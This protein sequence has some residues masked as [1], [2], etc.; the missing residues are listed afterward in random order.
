[1]LILLVGMAA[2]GFF[3]FRAFQ[4]DQGK[5]ATEPDTTAA[6][7]DD[8]D[9]PAA[10]TPVGE[11][12]EAVAALDELNSGATA[13]AG[14]LLGAVDDARDVMGQTD[15]GATTAD[16][17]ADDAT[18]AAPAGAGLTIADVL[19]DVVVAQGERLPD[20]SGRETYV[21]SAPTFSQTDA[22]AFGR[23]V[24]VLSSQPQIDPTSDVFAD[25]PELEPGAILISVDRDGDT[26]RRV[27]VVAADSG[28]YVDASQ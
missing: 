22:A 15:N 18:P 8:T 1:M 5:D 2:A 23:F 26:L 25:Y 10:L 11:Q 12:A 4:D 14:G 28:I 7:D 27:I 24:E 21:I 16:G 17:T 3:G 9:D 20:L 13:S 6:V 19:P